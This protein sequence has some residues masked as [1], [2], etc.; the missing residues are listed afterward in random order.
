MVL[1]DI[2]ITN[3]LKMKNLT[4]FFF[5]LVTTIFIGACSSDSEKPEEKFK[6]DNESFSLKN[7]KLYL[8][9]SGNY[10]NSNGDFVRRDYT[11]S[12]GTFVA[13]NGWDLA[14]YTDAT[15]LFA[16]ELFTPSDTDF[17]QGNYLSLYSLNTMTDNS[18]Y[19][20]GESTSEN[21][22]Y[23]STGETSDN[24]NIGGGMEPGETMTIKF[25]GGLSHWQL[26]E[27]SWLETPF[28]GSIFVTAKV[29][30]VRTDAK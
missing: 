9:Y 7:A 25:N 19:F 15:Y 5:L 3:P 2:C 14:H 18:V 16:F 1:K 13:G 26:I 6:A 4:I 11:I 17:L 27:N 8:T 24:F 20:Y 30:D 29:E 28:T 12:D 22:Y 21:E 23:E 10:S